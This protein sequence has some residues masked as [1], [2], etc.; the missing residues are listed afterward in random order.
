MQRV[1]IAMQKEGIM[2]IDAKIMSLDSTCIKV[3]PDGT[4]ALKKP[5]NKVSEE[6]EEVGT[7]SFM[8]SPQM[9]RLS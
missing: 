3:H 5:G 1:F 6:I 9:I 2:R 8:W 4:G 7:P